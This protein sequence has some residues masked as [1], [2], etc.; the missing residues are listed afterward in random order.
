MQGVKTLTTT[1]LTVVHGVWSGIMALIHHFL[2]FLYCQL[3]NK[4]IP[5]KSKTVVFLKEY[6]LGIVCFVEVITEKGVAERSHAAK[7]T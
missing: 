7:E 3:S 4:G 2:S 5:H 1:A 6:C